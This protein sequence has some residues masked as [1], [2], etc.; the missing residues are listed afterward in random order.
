MDRDRCKGCGRCVAACG[1][2]LISLEVFGRRKGAV[3]REAEACV[4]CGRCGE[5]CPLGVISLAAGQG[6]S[7]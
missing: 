5:E 6:S 7:D 2:A 3:F 1:M 4:R